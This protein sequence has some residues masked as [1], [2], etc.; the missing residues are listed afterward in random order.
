MFIK[1]IFVECMYWESSAEQGKLGSVKLV[2]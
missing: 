1:E 2:S